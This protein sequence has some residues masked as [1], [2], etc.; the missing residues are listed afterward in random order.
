MSVF[1]PEDNVSP[2]NL[3]VQIESRTIPI[4][5]VGGT[6]QT[7]L[8][9]QNQ[10]RKLCAKFKIVN[11]DPVNSITYRIPSPSAPLRTVPPSTSTLVE[12]YT[13]YLEFNYD[14]ANVTS[15]VE[16]DLVNSKDVKTRES[17]V[18]MGSA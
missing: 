17:V 6:T 10:F 11:E 4:N 12:E 7:K 8:N 5:S 9:T 3:T 13:Y 14:L 1:N 2:Q 16:L 15:Y 18:G